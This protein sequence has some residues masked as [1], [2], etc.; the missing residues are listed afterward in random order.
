MNMLQGQGAAQG[1]ATG[2]AALFKVSELS[3]DKIITEDFECE[4]NKLER[5]RKQYSLELSKLTEERDQSDEAVLIIETYQEILEDDTFFDEVCNRLLLEK[6]NIEYAI[7]KEQSIVSA[8][9]EK[10]DNEYLKERSADIENVCNEL[11][12]IIQGKE[13]GKLEKTAEKNEKIIVFARDLSPDQT[14]K[15][16]KGRIGGIVTERGGLTSHTVIL[17]KTLGIPAVVGAAGAMDAVSEGE[18][19]IIYGDSGRIYISP[20]DAAINEYREHNEKQN[21]LSKEFERALENKAMTLDGESIEVCFNLADWENEEELAPL[22]TS[23]GIGLYRTEFIY[24]HSNDYPDE[25]KQFSYYRRV[26]E[27]ADGKDVIIR[28]LDIGGDKQ[29]DYMDLPREDNPFL[30]YRAIRLCLNRED[31][32]TTQLRAILRASA[33]GKVSIMYPMIASAEELR[34]ANKYLEKAKKEL[35]EADIE[36]DENIRTGIMIETPAAV[37]LSDIL[38]RE[39]DFFSIGTNDLIQY[40]VAA[41]RMNE[42]VQYLYTPKSPAVLRSISLVCKNAARYNTRV[43]MCGEA[44]SDASLIPVWAAMGLTELSVVPAQVARTKY[45]INH[46]NKSEIR[47]SLDKILALETT[48]EVEAFLSDLKSHYMPELQ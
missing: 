46:I 37:L 25:E 30:G 26:A 44:A 38:A 22:D 14:L 48:E 7:R 9:F 27:R 39:C 6:C 36:F 2:V 11:I 41:D 43:H 34:A 24:I 23:D 8:E 12:R 35:R 1:C 32:F 4:K 29:A 20:D 5:A 33:Y 40:T 19:V 28:T 21:S 13:G 18:T 3:V 45:I 16:D 10:I 17:A 42:N 31:I 47:A 15:M